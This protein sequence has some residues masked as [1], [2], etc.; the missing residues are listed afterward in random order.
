[1]TIV[2]DIHIEGPGYDNEKV[3]GDGG[4]AVKIFLKFRSYCFL[5]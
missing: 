4:L 5:L 2:C 3:N 1:M